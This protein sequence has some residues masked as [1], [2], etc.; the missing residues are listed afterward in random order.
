MQITIPVRINAELVGV[1]DEERKTTMS[2]KSRSQLIR[3]I[4]S[5]WAMSKARRK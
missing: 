5:E 1:L 2:D 4:L 3:D